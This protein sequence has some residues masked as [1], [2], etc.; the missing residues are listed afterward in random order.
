MIP[1]TAIITGYIV[2]LGF[3]YTYG[4]WSSYNID[5]QVVL[6]LISPLDMVKFLIMPFITAFFFTAFY[7]LSMANDD[8]IADEKEEKIKLFKRYDR[9]IKFLQFIFF[10]YGIYYSYKY[11]IQEIDFY[12]SVIYC[13]GFSIVI[14]WTVNHYLLKLD[15]YN[16]RRLAFFAFIFIF[17]PGLCLN[18]GHVKG[19][20]KIEESSLVMK[21]HSQCSLDTSDQF[22]LLAIYS[23]KGISI[24]VKTKSI[25]LFDTENQSFINY[26]PKNYSF[27]LDKKSI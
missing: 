27:P 6:G 20:P 12:G 24:S 25:C 2:L 21:G 8:V 11:L 18:L 22:V 23:Q 3:A 16:S 7:I 5:F 15:Y 14:F 9:T 26:I 19:E 13:F 1:L 17:L 10:L 4:Y